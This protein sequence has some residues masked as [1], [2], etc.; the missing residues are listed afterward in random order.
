MARCI[1]DD[2]LF[3][4]TLVNAQHGNIILTVN[5]LVLDQCN[6]RHG[7]NG[8]NGVADRQF[9]CTAS[10]LLFVEQAVYR[11]LGQKI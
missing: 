9:G 4:Y 8:W 3:G 1:V 7:D 6:V 2:V 10:C 11:N 5:G